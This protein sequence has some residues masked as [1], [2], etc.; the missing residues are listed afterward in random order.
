M[1]V[2]CA[3][4]VGVCVVL[5][6]PLG[7]R[8]AEEGDFTGGKNKHPTPYPKRRVLRYCVAMSGHG[9]FGC[10]DSLSEELA[11]QVYIQD[12]S[13]I[14]FIRGLRMLGSHAA[15]EGVVLGGGVFGLTGVSRQLMTYPP[16]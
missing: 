6:A 13:G 9:I 3:E 10:R 5:I 1:F 4:Q 8:G 2:N 14:P 11:Y 7:V 16:I 15:V 12:I